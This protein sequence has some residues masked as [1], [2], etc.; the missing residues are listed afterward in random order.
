MYREVNNLRKTG[1]SD[2]I[3]QVNITVDVV[4]ETSVCDIII[5]LTTERIFLASL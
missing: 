3:R 2:F 4:V 5:C 1:Q